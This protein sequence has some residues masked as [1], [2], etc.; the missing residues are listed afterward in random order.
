[1]L[2]L[3]LAYTHACMHICIL[4]INS[5]YFTWNEKIFREKTATFALVFCCDYWFGRASGWA[6][7][8]ERVRPN[9]VP[10]VLSS[11]PIWKHVYIL[12]SVCCC[13]FFVLFAF[14]GQCIT[15][16]LCPSVTHLLY[17]FRIISEI[18]IYYD[19]WYLSC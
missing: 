12:L 15:T 11:E 6:D 16:F 5:I 8:R 14:C 18:D 10:I 9:D 2:L 4:T 7:R 3:L 13:F 1:M 17:L 19:F